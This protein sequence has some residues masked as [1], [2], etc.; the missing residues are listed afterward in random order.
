M[1][2]CCILMYLNSAT[3]MIGRVLSLTSALLSAHVPTA[4]TVRAL[5]PAASYDSTP[6]EPRS[7]HAPRRDHG[8]VSA[9][10]LLSSC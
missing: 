6:T 1:N 9:P 2:R 3:A 5:P 10:R 7:G 8:V 4:W